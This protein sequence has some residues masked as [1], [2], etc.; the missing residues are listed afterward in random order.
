[1]DTPYTKHQNVKLRDTGHD[2]RWLQDQIYEDPTILGLGELEIWRKE[3]TQKAGGRLDF[4]LQDPETDLVYEVEV[5]LGAT[6]E[7]HIIRTIEY[8]DNERRRFPNRDHRAV[9]VAEEITNRFFNIVWLLNRAIPIIAVQMNALVVDGKLILNFTKVL[10]IYEPE[11]DDEDAEPSEI[12]DRSYWEKKSSVDSVKFLDE[13]LKAFQD[14]GFSPKIKYRR[15]M[16]SMV[17]SKNNFGGFDLRKRPDGLVIR[18]WP[19]TSDILA[20]RAK[21]EEAGLMPAARKD[22]SLALRLTPQ[23]LQSHGKAIAE[24]SQVADKSRNAAT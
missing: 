1:M 7:S 12:A 3:R 13:V 18:L 2:E 9:I 10:D 23:V 16:V 15:D 6:D 14:L 11:Q 4:L 8:W 5:M 22:G 20:V 21:L 19:R 17:G 24:A